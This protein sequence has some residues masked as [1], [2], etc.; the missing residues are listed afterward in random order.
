MV[1]SEVLLSLELLQHDVELDPRQIT[2][3]AGPG[4]HSQMPNASVQFL[5]LLLN[6]VLLHETDCHRN[7]AA[8]MPTMLTALKIDLVAESYEPS[9]SPSKS[10]A[11]T[12]SKHQIHR[13]SGVGGPRPQLHSKYIQATQPNPV[14]VLDVYVRT[15]KYHL[16]EFLVHRHLC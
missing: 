15:K 3:S 7:S 4:S 11:Q 14:H 8:L 10:N 6:Q 16:Q 2:S 1:D 9:Q 12:T 13:T 5:M